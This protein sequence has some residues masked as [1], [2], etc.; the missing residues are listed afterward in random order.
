MRS[1]ISKPGQSIWDIAIRYMGGVESV[2]TILELNPSLS[3]DLTIPNETEIF[4]PDKADNQRVVDY[5]ELNN[6]QPSTG[7]V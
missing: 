4:L 6:I 5:Y 3:V 2:F 7:I 1:V